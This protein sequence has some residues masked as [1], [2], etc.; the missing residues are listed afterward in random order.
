MKHLS[1]TPHLPAP[2][3]WACVLTPD[4]GV[5]SRL[6]FREPHLLSL[7][8]S[9]VMTPCL[10]SETGPYFRDTSCFLPASRLAATLATS[11]RIITLT[12]GSIK[13]INRRAYNWQERT[14]PPISYYAT[15]GLKY[16]R[17]TRR[18]STV[19]NWETTLSPSAASRLPP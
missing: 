6:A 8:P 16:S 14:R 4:S 9:G 15:A 17:N 12:A 19:C 13:E 5:V 3:P 10:L 1:A 18:S 2:K 11:G 7:I